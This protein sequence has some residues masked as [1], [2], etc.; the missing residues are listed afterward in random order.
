MRKKDLIIKIKLVF[1]KMP[2]LKSKLKRFNYMVG[3]INNIRKN[4]KLLGENIMSIQ[5]NLQ[6]KNF[7]KI[8]SKKAH[9]DLYQ[10]KCEMKNNIF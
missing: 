8:A 9:F 4:K 7:I 3:R 10:S 6:K 2:E 1:K 5:E